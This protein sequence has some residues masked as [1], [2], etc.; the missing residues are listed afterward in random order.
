MQIRLAHSLGQRGLPARSE[1]I[2][3]A[4][5]A[6]ACLLSGAAAAAVPGGPAF[7]VEGDY[8]TLTT[9]RVYENRMTNG[10]QSIDYAQYRAATSGA[11]GLR[12]TSGYVLKFNRVTAFPRLSIGYVPHTEATWS[13]HG[14]LDDYAFK[15]DRRVWSIDAGAEMQFFKR[16]FLLEGAVGIASAHSSYHLPGFS[17]RP[18]Y[19]AAILGYT[20]QR[21]SASEH[22]GLLIHLATGWRA[23][24]Q[25][26]VSF[27]FKATAEAV[28]F[29]QGIERAVTFP[30][31]RAML[32]VFIEVEPLF[33]E[34]GSV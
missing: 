34:G 32:S 9:T 2:P 30:V 25:S 1:L 15:V 19:D 18:A 33:T 24:L 17:V 23:P 6:A 22:P 28:M 4:L 5:G 29:T 12:V 7:R 10:S 21:P 11:F 3:A 31:A 26:P 14:T 20:D 16:Q 13:L 8:G 27:G